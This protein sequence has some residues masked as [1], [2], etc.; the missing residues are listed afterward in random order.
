MWSPNNASCKLLDLIKSAT[1]SL[2]VEAEEINNKSIENV[3]IQEAQH[4]INV[5]VIVPPQKDMADIR[6][7]ITG[8]VS[9]R[10]LPRKPLYM[11]TKLIIA[12]GE[13]GFIGSENLSA[14]SLQMNREL[15]TLIYPHEHLQRITQFFET[16]WKNTGQTLKGLR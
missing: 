6:H 9:V 3:L 14:Y 11:H 5:R 13:K 2:Y 10:I 7:L 12:D 15:G 16:D 1:N 8:N 4:G